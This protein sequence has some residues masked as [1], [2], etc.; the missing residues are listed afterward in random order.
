M[1][2]RKQSRISKI[3]IEVKEILPYSIRKHS[4]LHLNTD[5]DGT[6]LNTDADGTDLTT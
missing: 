1:S 2:Q 3:Q 6:D 5:A 4:I